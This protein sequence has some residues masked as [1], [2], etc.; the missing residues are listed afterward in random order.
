VGRFARH[1]RIIPAAE[2]GSIGATARGAIVRYLG[3][4]GPDAP[5]QIH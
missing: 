4:R 5:E 3:Q 1:A 2:F